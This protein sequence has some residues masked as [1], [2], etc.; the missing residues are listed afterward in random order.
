MKKFFVGGV[1]SLIVVALCFVFWS[2]LT[3]TIAEIDLP[4]GDDEPDIPSMLKNAKN[5]VT[6][7]EFLTHRAEYFGLLR[8]INKTKEV[9]P[10]LRQ[11]AIEQ[12]GQQQQDFA[13]SPNGDNALLAAWNPIGP[14]PII[15]G[16][17]RYSGRTISIAVHPTNPNIVYVGA[18]QGGLYR[19]T[20]GGINWVSLMDSA[21]SIAIGAIAISPSQPET[22]YIGTGEHNFSADSFF[23]VGV[24]RIKNA[25]TTANLT[26]PLNKDGGN[27][28]IFSGRG[29]SKIIVHPSDPN[30]IFVASTSGVGGIGGGASNALPSRGI[31]RSTNAT[32]TNPTFEK[33]TGLTGNINASV[34][35]IAIDPNNANILVAGL[36]AS[37]GTGGLYTS[38]DALSANPTF[39]QTQILMLLQQVN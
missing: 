35:D 3:K 2:P 6:K 28:D 21:D 8:G 29:I 19:S 20:D 33:L 5:S 34:R 30:T 7:E 15:S 27:N 31:Y 10:K 24:Y 32:T 13:R 36:V 22:V 18:A 16:G 23:G 11:I 4:F 9:D 12:M 39:T 1:L 38:T 14:A 26:G 17:S 37:G 25:S